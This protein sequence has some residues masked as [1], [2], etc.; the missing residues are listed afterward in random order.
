MNDFYRVADALARPRIFAIATSP[1]DR[2]FHFD[3]AMLKLETTLHSKVFGVS[4]E[5]RDEILALPDRPSE[6]VILYD[7][8]NPAIESNL[9]KQLKQLD[10]SHTIFQTHFY[11]SHLALIEIGPCAS[12][13]IWRRALKD[14]DAAVQPSYEEDDGGDHSVVITQRRIRDLVKNWSFMMPNLDASSRGFNVTPKFLKLV[15]TLKSCESHGAGFRGIVFGKLGGSYQLVGVLNK[16]STTT[17]Y[18]IC[19]S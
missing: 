10:P 5:E 11:A 16:N 17:D 4:V 12:D 1:T 14:I 13:L 19:D 2:G 7:K 18:C 15:Q 8:P 9:F 6:V 3:S